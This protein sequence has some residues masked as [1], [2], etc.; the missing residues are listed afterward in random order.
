[1][2]IFSLTSNKKKDLKMLTFKWKLAKGNAI[3]YGSAEIQ[4]HAFC[5]LIMSE[6]A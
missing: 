2:Q 4:I 5:L 6:T 3:N 1:M